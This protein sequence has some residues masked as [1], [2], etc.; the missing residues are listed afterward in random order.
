MLKRLALWAT[1]VVALLH[2]AFMVLE[3]T[4]WSTELGQRLTHLSAS[5]AGETAGVFP[6]P[7]VAP[8]L[9]DSTRSYSGFSKRHSPSP[10]I[11]PP[12]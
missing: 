1:M 4:Q 8:F 9:A 6:R 2:L 11:C 3:A 5:A 12:I 7:P 10:T